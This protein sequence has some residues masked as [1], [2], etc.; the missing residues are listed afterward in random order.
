V[1]YHD[2]AGRPSRGQLLFYDQTAAALDEALEQVRR[3]ARPGDLMATTV[4]HWAYLRTGVKAVL[5]PMERDRAVANALLDSV[6]A[7]FVVLD[8]L[9]YPRISQRYAA[10]AVEGQPARWR[11]VYETTDGRARLYERVPP[12]RS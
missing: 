2:A 4:P 3:R 12:T 10:P 8:E 9:A 7:R 5:P 1:I 6:A 11:K